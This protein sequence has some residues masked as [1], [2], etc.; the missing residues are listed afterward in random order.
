MKSFSQLLDPKLEDIKLDIPTLDEAL[1][2]KDLPSE[3]TDGLTIEKHKKSNSKTTVFVVKTQ[4][5]DGDRD[6]VE[7]K[8][9][10]AD[11][12][13]EVKGSSLS[14]FDPIFI[15]SLNGDRAIIMFKPKSG[16]MNETTLNSS[17]TE[18]FPCIAWEK[19]YKPSSV[20]SFYEW[21]LTQD[22]DKLKCVG[23]SDKQSAKDFIA[24]AEDSSKFTE[25]VEN[26]IGITKYIYDEMKEK[27]IKNVFW[28]YR[29][30][31]AGV[32][33]KHP[34][35]I[36]LQ[37]IDG[38]ILGT[39]LKAGGKKTS[40]PKLNTYVN[41]IFQAFKVGNQVPKLSAK[42]HKEVFSKIEGMPS[43]KTY[44]SKDRKI[45][46]QILKD[47]D[48]NNNGKYEQYYNEHL[49]IVR[50]ALIDLFNKNG[51]QGGKS[52][53]YIKKEILREAPGVP[54][55][56]IKGIGSTYEQVTDDDELGVFLPVV[57]FI[58][59]EASKSS[60]QNWFLHL[61]SKDTTY[62]M[63]MSVRTNKAG[64]AGLKK[65]GQFYN[66]AVKYNGLLKK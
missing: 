60:K 40:E 56:V 6:E 14:S 64:H 31:P 53:D 27:A 18:L 39:S 15:P 49:E 66:L 3:V 29:A 20:S 13:A 63:Q 10:N 43:A 58:K 45:T 28:G 48:K 50:Q 46:Q 30:K 55:K 33:S 17:I 59:A 38:A 24:Q 12:H 5:R 2:V 7:K 23:S 16:G 54:T 35:D 61:A 32:P 65:L 11:I 21:I 9:R 47:F 44:D 1:E 57:K 41:P 4:D 26:A 51:K 8:L 37:F 36:F 62:T 34:G 52:F 19:N 22:V 25:K 42:L